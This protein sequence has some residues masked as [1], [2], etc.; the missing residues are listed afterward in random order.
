[1]PARLLLLP[2]LCAGCLIASCTGVPQEDYPSLAIRDIERVTGT[3]APVAPTYVPPPPPDA[4]LD[5]LDALLAQA[6][7]AHASFSDQAPAL[8]NTIGAAGGAAVGSESWARAT[9]ALAQ[10]EAIRSEAM[11]ALADLDA[12]YAA[13]ATEGQSLE[14]VAGVR[15]QVIALVEEEDGVIAQLGARVPR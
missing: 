12:I 1:M 15:E 14:R 10:L 7:T 11:V 2:V 8:G 4:S 6:Q 9:V 13:A 5:R 3:L